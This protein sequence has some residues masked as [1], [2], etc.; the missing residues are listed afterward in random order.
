MLLFSRRS[1]LIKD[2]APWIDAIQ[3]E[4]LEPI[5]SKERSWFEAETEAK[6]EAINIFIALLV[7]GALTPDHSRLGVPFKAHNG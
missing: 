6:R 2:V 7:G 4:P 5:L 3:F 1:E